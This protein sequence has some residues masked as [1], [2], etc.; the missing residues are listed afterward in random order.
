MNAMRL[1]KKF[2]PFVAALAVA[3]L[4]AIPVRADNPKTDKGAATEKKAAAKKE[5]MDIN[6]ATAKE[7]QTLPGIGEAY[8]KKIIEGRPYRGKNELVDKKIIPAAT[9]NKIKDQIIAKQK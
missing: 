3:S 6:S 7:L 5:L 4:V 1:L 2:L 9:Y 8:S